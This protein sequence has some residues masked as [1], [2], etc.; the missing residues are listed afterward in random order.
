MRKEFSYDER[1]MISLQVGIWG[2]KLQIPS[3]DRKSAL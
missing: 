2:L 1:T 3:L